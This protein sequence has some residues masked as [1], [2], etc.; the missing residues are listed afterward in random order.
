M[1]QRMRAELSSLTWE[2]TKGIVLEQVPMFSAL[3]GLPL[4]LPT[5]PPHAGVVFTEPLQISQL[6]EQWTLG[7]GKWA[8]HFQF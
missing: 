6:A 2:R 3:L 8:L 5:Q 7:A 4:A 1:E